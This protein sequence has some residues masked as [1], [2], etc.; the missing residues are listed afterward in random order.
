MSRPGDYHDDVPMKIS[1]PHAKSEL[2]SSSTT[3][4]LFIAVNL[5]SLPWGQ[6]VGSRRLTLTRPRRR[7]LN[8]G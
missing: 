3:G 5:T 1:L 8:I 6:P 2:V 7:E 4:N